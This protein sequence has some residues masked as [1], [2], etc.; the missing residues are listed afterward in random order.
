MEQAGVKITYSI[1]GLKVH[2]KAVLVNKTEPN[3]NKI[4]YG[5]FGTGNFNEKTANIYTDHGLL[6]TDKNLTTE[7]KRVFR[8]LYNQNTIPSFKYLLVSQFNILDQFNALIDN[9][10]QNIKSGKKGHILI[11]VNNLEDRRMIDRLYEASMAGVKITIIV[12]SICCL[13]PGLKPSGKNIKI[14]R[15]VDR[16]LEHSRIFVF[17]NGGR[18]KVFMGS[19]DWMKRNLSGRIEVIFPVKNDILKKEVIRYLAFQLNDNTKARLLDEKLNNN[20]ILHKNGAA[21]IRAQFH[22][23]DWI[24]NKEN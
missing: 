14:V 3:G 22:I 23:Y 2:A 7:L 11:K 4:A 13:I 8:Y 1:P 16:Y 15:L 9:E 10:I 18:K 19:A 12:R 6:T 21:R 17:H 24:K 20:R 5:Y